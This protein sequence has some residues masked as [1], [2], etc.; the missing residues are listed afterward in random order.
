M[1]KVNIFSRVVLSMFLGFAI[2]E[3]VRSQCVPI[4]TINTTGPGTYVVPAGVTTITVEVWGAGGRGGTRTNNGRGG[5]GG[6][7]AYSRSTFFVTPGQSFSYNVGVGSSNPSPGGD[8]WFV[9]NA[10]LMAKGGSSA[11]NNNNNGA[12]GGLASEGFGDIRFSGGNG[13]NQSGSG[14]G[15]G[16]SSAGSEANGTNGAVVT[17]GVAPTGGGNGGAGTNTVNTNGSPGFSPGGGGGGAVRTSGT[18]TGGTGGNGQIIISACPCFTILDD[19]A[20]SG[21]NIIQFNADCDWEA[22][23][24][25]LEFDVLAVAGGGGGGFGNGGGGGGGGI[26]PANVNI[27]LKDPQGLPAGTTF[28]INVGR[29]GNGSD[30]EEDQGEDG[31]DSSFDLGG[32]YQVVAGGGGGG[33][34]QDEGE[35]RDGRNSSVL[36]GSSGLTS[37]F[38]RGGSGGGG[39]DDEDGG[40]GVNAGGN[41]G[42]SDEDESGGGG[43]G[44]GGNGQDSDES[45]GGNG[46]IGLRFSDFDIDLDRF[47]GAGG[48]GGGEDSGGNGGSSGSGGAGGE[49]DEA[50]QNGLSPGTGGGGGADDARGGNGAR[51][52]VYVVYLNARIL[53]VEYLFFDVNY[54]TKSNT[55]KL[56]W[57]TSKEWENQ[58][59]E[60]QRSVANVENFE[61]I[62]E[63]AGKGWS[64]TESR[65]EF[66]DKTLPLTSGMVYYR[67][68]QVDFDGTFAYSKVIS[69]KTAGIKSTTG[70]WRAYPN[71]TTGERLRV[72][73]LDASQYDNE[74]IR[75]RLLHPTSLSKAETVNSE[76][77]MNLAL[78]DLLVAMPKGVFVIEIQWGQKVEHIKVL[79]TN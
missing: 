32:F 54:D 64:D 42:D 2:T 6:G 36:S 76:E 55:S 52:I 1:N 69:V 39:A 21:V 48:G 37:V 7:G 5:G 46:G 27:E 56:A 25:L 73:L 67:L 8:T 43:G 63:V 12:A 51:G 26:V 61:T 58:G 33:G 62:G 78:Q 28:S 34:S 70:V 44:A 66:E 20:V 57:A 16:G 4:E 3:Q 18:R 72:S 22:P 49:D 41:G 24:G 45:D 11:G 38:L 65:Y 14:S 9:N 10:T 75:F 31:E 13:A 35:G 68:K 79:K 53:P 15:G 50:G 30:D 77:E 60:I 74:E 19:G 17:G 23:E 71:P 40:N 47:F 29:G 59:F